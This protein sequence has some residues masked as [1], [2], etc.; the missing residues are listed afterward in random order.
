MPAFTNAEI[1]PVG[2]AAGS[3]AK[4]ALLSSEVRAE[5]S[6]IMAHAEYMELSGRSDFQEEFSEAMIF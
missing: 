6:E 1:I 3:G 2:N 4:V 5:A